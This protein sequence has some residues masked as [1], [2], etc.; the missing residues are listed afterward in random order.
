MKRRD[1]K[2]RDFIE[3]EGRHHELMNCYI[4]H[5]PDTKK[6]K[7]QV[8]DLADLQDYHEFVRDDEADNEAY[9]SSYKIRMA[10]RY[11]D[12]LFR[13]YAII[14]LSRFK[15][16][17][18][19][20]RWRIESEVIAGKSQF[21]CGEKHCVATEGLQ[22]YEVPF[23]YTEAGES[24]AELVKVRICPSCSVRLLEASKASIKATDLVE[25]EST[26]TKKVKLRRKKYE[27]SVL[28]DD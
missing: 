11:Y 16:R 27:A 10:R 2:E 25:V 18:I 4:A 7:Y 28:I 13:E 22:T 9:N 24:K 21:I 8:S 17:K 5:K 20:L 14:D 1:S 3:N 6:Q 19:G 12:R 26:L 15:E 23:S